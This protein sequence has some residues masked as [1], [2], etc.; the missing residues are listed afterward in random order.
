MRD[1]SSS[2][3]LPRGVRDILPEEAE[4]IYSVE[5]TIIDVFHEQGF[6]RVITP[7]VEY[8]DVLSKGLDERLKE[9]LFKFIDPFTGRVVAIRPDIT[10]QIARMV[11]TKMR[12]EGLPL[13]L[14]YNENIFR[15]VNSDDSSA[16]EFFQIGAEYISEQARPEIDA[17]MITMAMEALKRLGIEDFRMDIGEI[18]FVKSVMRGVSVPAPVKKL[19]KDAIAKKDSGTL[20]EI[21]KENKSAIGADT[22]GL[23]LTLTEL[24][25]DPSVIDTALESASREELKGHLLYVKEVVE[26]VSS[27]GF[28]DKLTIDLG[29]VR[30]FTYYTGIIFECFCGRTGR[31]ILSGGRYDNLM[32]AYG[33]DVKSTGFAFDVAGLVNILSREV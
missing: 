5:T 1:S 2:I 19:I 27:K 10:P 25:G 14:Y 30:G 18:G 23:L 20:R 24:Y 8:V 6:R 21:I 33:Y 15:S 16:T 22:E 12:T 13:K 4:R 11:A 26:I 29:E 17:Q 28:A 3:S 31:A 32:S 7:L 9:R